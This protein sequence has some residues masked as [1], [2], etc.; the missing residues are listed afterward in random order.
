MA[1]PSSSSS[2][3]T[4]SPT[5][6]LKQGADSKG[7]P[8]DERRAL[9]VVI[10][11][12]PDDVGA[13]VRCEE[14]RVANTYHREE[15]MRELRELFEGL[16]Y[17][18]DVVQVTL[19]D[20]EEVLAALPTQD[21]IV[22]LCDGSEVDGMP[23]VSVA[24]CLE[25]LRFPAVFGCGSAFIDST[26][27]KHTM[28]QLFDRAGV[29]TPKGT[30]IQPGTDRDQIR[31][32]LAGLT[33]PLFV[34]ASDSYGSVSIT[35]ES[36]C[37]T[38]DEAVDLAARLVPTFGT[39]VVEEFIDGPEYTV[40]VLGNAGQTTGL[41]QLVVYPPAQRTFPKACDS[42][43]CFLTFNSNW[44]ATAACQDVSVEDPADAPPLEEI[45]RRA[46]SAVGGTGFGRVDFRKRRATNEFFVLEVNA[47][48]GVGQGSSSY[49][50]LRLA[51]LTTKD[52]MQ[53]GVDSALQ[54]ATN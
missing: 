54:S 30:A 43:H 8:A 7:S 1:P 48:C 24:R 44:V 52:F 9:H 46:Y 5:A 32:Q 16:G 51:N 50:I 29:P 10:C 31:R 39:V 53:R 13:K 34:K 22:N 4:T 38:F 45:A 6:L 42:E 36:L 37:H 17:R 27:C 49:H 14:E 33:L 28:K 2:V 25:R 20:Y 11:G 19:K 3:A 47:C 26:T 21:I 40:L 41:D 15:E 12:A 35:D 18:A 23:G